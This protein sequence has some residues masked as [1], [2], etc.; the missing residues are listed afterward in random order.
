MILLKTSRDAWL[1]GPPFFI[2]CF[3][4]RGQGAVCGERTGD[5]GDHTLKASRD[6]HRTPPEWIMTYICIYTC[7]TTVDEALTSRPTTCDLPHYP[8]PRG[9]FQEGSTGGRGE[10]YPRSPAWN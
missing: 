6:Q 9:I 8:S 7:E 2:T 10:G 1:L 5:G 4:Y 3:I